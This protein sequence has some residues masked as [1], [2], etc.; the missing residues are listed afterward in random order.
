MS[1]SVKLFEH[2]PDSLALAVLS[3]PSAFCK[4]VL[5]L[6]SDS[7]RFARPRGISVGSHETFL[8]LH[9]N[10]IYQSEQAA[11]SL[12]SLADPRTFPDFPAPKLVLANPE[13][14]RARTNPHLEKL[15][16]IQEQVGLHSSHDLRPS[17][18]WVPWRGCSFSIQS[19]L[20][21]KDLNSLP[22]EANPKW[23]LYFFFFVFPFPLSLVI[24]QCSVLY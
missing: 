3:D 2:L 23:L 13:P 4:L 5:V 21:C 1:Y 14:E 11:S 10:F 18:K 6:R 24:N 20:I 8:I 22:P 15:Q 9:S 12:V 17:I 7:S 16:E 19:D